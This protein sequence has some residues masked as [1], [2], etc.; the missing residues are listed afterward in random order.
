MLSADKLRPTPNRGRYMFHN[1]ALRLAVGGFDLALKVLP[2]P[3]HLPLTAN[4]REILVCNQAHIGDVIL[5]SSALPVLKAA[6]PYAKIGFLVHPASTDVLTGNPHV[7]RVHTHEHWKLNRRKIP[8]WNKV[9]AHF[10]SRSNAIREIKAVGYDLAIDLYH[11]FP[12]SIPLL[13]STGIPLRLGWTSGGFGDLLTHALDWEYAPESAVE[14]TK[15]LLGMIE[16]CREHIALARPQLYSTQGVAL[17]WDRIAVQHGIRA[18][19]ASFHLGAGG[20]HKR[21]PEEHWKE[22]A[23]LCLDAG[24]PI[25]LLGHGKEDEQACRRIASLSSDIFDLSG[26]LSWPLMAEAIGHSHFLVGLESACAHVAAA[27]NVPGVC[28]Y[29]GIFHH[30]V[31]RP[32]HPMARV[33]VHPTP[34]S[35][36][37]ISGGCEGMECVRRTTAETVFAEIQSLMEYKD[38]HEHFLPN[39][40]RA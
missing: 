10:R 19:Y 2:S 32:V 24:W 9:K 7:E 4:P 12:N 34:C 39:V 8:F 27:R 14:W 20:A 33:L 36:C 15:R 40:S 35:P 23:K 3:S 17:E 6:F 28:I 31:W 11:Y 37:H 29:S 21:W 16:P 25:A 1:R 5:A 30:S 26:K 18:G 22:L 13:F 38:R